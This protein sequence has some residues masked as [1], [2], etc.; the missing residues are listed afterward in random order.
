M[1]N[2]KIDEPFGIN[3]ETTLNNN[4]PKLIEFASWNALI[5]MNTFFSPQRN[6]QS[7]LEFP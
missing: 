2:A 1:G 4:G 5:I 6:S 3:G 7:N